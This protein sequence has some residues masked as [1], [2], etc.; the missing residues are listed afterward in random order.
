MKAICVTLNPALDKYFYLPALQVG[1]LNRAEGAVAMTAGGKGINVARTLKMLGDE[2]V[3]LFLAGGNTGKWME[4][5]L[6][7]EGQKSVIIKT[8]ASTRIC[9]KIV[10]PESF[11]E[12]NEKGG[13]ITKEETEKALLS[14]AE[15]LGDVKPH[16]VI[17]SGSL[18]M[19]MDKNI[20]IRMMEKAA[21]AG[22]AVILDCDGET[23]K[24]GIEKKPFL[25]KPNLYELCQ[26][27]GHPLTDKQEIQDA[28]LQLHQKEGIE[29]LCTLGADGAVYAGKNGLFSVTSPKVNASKP[30][31]AG[32][33]FLAGYLSA[34]FQ[35]QTP[36]E[37]LI[38]AVQTAAGKLESTDGFPI[39]LEKEKYRSQ[40]VCTK[41]S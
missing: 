12:I 9:T 34:Y 36:S 3:N 38:R 13:P 25:I 19:G 35:E 1:S 22:A 4:D 11:T 39:P 29:I 16:C 33:T 41:I 28:C 2:A 18:P 8:T 20:Y 15:V 30:S 37:C 17:L 32:D 5:M 23:L 7:E 27:I 6:S 24:K 26:L 31:G 21:L 10:T 40:I 14:L